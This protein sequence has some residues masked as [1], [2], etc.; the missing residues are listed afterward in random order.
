MK[1]LPMFMILIASFLLLTSCSPKEK[2]EIAPQGSLNTV[3][4][5]DF[6]FGPSTLT[7][8][9]GTTVIWTNDDSA[10]H[11]IESGSFKSSTLKNGESYS[12]KFD[13]KGEYDYICGIHPTMQGKIIVG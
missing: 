1:I 7:V 2:E 6:A 3:T 9:Q 12:F 4:I 11:T 5:K 13:G 10:P 8:A